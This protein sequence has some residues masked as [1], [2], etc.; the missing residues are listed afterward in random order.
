MIK[1]EFDVAW[2]CPM[3]E[4]LER[5]EEYNGNIESFVANGPGGGNPALILVFP[6]TEMA[7]GFID[8]DGCPFELEDVIV[9]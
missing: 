4:F 8:I 7:Q 1:I 9:E 6:S 3:G 2:D 5:L